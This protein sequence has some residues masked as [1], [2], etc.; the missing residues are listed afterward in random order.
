MAISNASVWEV[1]GT[2][3]NDTNGGAFVAGATG[4][5]YSQQGA[6]NTVGNDISTTDAVAVGTTTLTSATANFTTAIVGNV[7]YLSGG[8]GVLTAGWY[9]VTARTNSTTVTLDRTVGA[10][11]GITM[12]IGGALASVVQAMANTS[13]SNKIFVR[14]DGT[15]VQT[16]SATS[17]VNGGNNNVTPKNLIQGYSTTRGDSG[18]ATIQL[19]TNTGLT[20]INVTS[21]E[22]D[23]YNLIIDCNNLGTSTG[24]SGTSQHFAQNC[25]I[26]NFTKAG[27]AFNGVSTIQNCEITAG[28]NAATGAIVLAAAT[29]FVLDCYIHDNACP[30]INATTGSANTFLRNVIANNS[31]ASSDGIINS[32]GTASPDFIMYNTIYN[33]GR[34]G[35]NWSYATYGGG[36]VA[37]GNV[38]SNNGG[39][40]IMAASAAGNRNYASWD[41][42]AFFNNTSGTI[43]N[44][45]DTTVNKQ[46]GIGPYVSVFNIST[47]STPFVNPTAGDWRLNQNGTGGGLIRSLGV[48]QAWPGLSGNRSWPDFGAIEHQ[49][50]GSASG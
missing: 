5:D 24:I 11:T 36:R 49:D 35:I 20:A 12:N 33:N 2:T 28:T 7:I 25:L 10:G 21:L 27:I 48:P 17:G 39:Y 46:N 42:N 26:K 8:T 18:R 31:G 34:H 3:G 44:S 32:S 16:A 15:Y 45:N 4:T 13:Q 9:Q 50:P 22:W 1:R 30:G 47:T 6:K 41:G 43:N 19:S 38:L 29:T 37:M 23:F 40:G 14:D